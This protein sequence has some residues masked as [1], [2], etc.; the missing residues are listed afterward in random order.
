M[1]LYLKDVFHSGLQAFKCVTYMFIYVQ[2]YLIF[3][4]L[5]FLRAPQPRP[6]ADP[7]STAQ[8]DQITKK[9]QVLFFSF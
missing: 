7:F 2:L 8:G 1:S 5:E 9:D 3:Q 6:S 4:E